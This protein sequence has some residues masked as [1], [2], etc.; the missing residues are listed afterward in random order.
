LLQIGVAPSKKVTV[1]DG[2]P[3][4]GA[5][6][7]SV[8][9]NVIDWPNSVDGFD[10]VTTV[11]VAAG[12]TFCVVLP[13]EVLKS[14]SPEYV[15][16]IVC[17]ATERALVVHVAVP[18]GETACAPQPAIA[19]TPSVKAMVPVGVPAPGPETTVVEVNVTPSPKT[20]GVFELTTAVVVAVF[21]TTC[22]KTGDVAALKFPSALYVAV[23]E[24]DAIV[25][26]DVMHVA[27]LPVSGAA[28]QIAVAPS[29]KST[30]PVGVPTAGAV[31]ETVAVNVTDCPMLEGFGTPTTTAV[32]SP[33]LTVC[34]N[35]AE[36]EPLKSVD[37]AYVAVMF[38]CVPTAR[39]DV[40]HVAT[41]ALS[42]AA[43]HPAIGVALSKNATVPAGAPAPGATTA[44]VALMAMD[45]PKRLGAG[46]LAS[47]V[48][49]EGLFTV[50]D[51][52][53]LLAA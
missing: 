42:V 48:V 45:S 25:S 41:P 9:V 14:V 17:D 47:V 26:V 37:P 46:M 44:T 22:V 16:T 30:L 1:P 23:I 2:V 32:E 52:V 35:G 15:A 19:L 36:V 34:E 6:T 49:V 12:E 27:V 8:A 11:E 51:A 29:K 3:A 28:V 31:T 33:L 24:C 39:A 21:V 4:P 53:L 5:V 18:A 50:C 43:E 10:V 40:L 38:A 7:L 13:L 20:V